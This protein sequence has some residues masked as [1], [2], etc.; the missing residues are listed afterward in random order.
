MHVLCYFPY[1]LCMFQCKWHIKR[2]VSPLAADLVILNVVAE[3][4]W[5]CVQINVCVWWVFTRGHQDACRQSEHRD[6]VC[7]GVIDYQVAM[8]EADCWRLLWTPLLTSSVRDFFLLPPHSLSWFSWLHLSAI[9]FSLSPVFCLYRDARHCQR[10]LL[11][12]KNHYES[13]H[14]PTVHTKT[15]KGLAFL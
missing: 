10:K 15:I 6:R 3:V 12:H 1:F 7:E 13:H 5:C 14:R 8:R 2:R 11:M 4:V 9:N